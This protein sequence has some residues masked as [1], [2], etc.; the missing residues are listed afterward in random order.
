MEG[1]FKM[2]EKRKKISL[3]IL[4]VVLEVVIFMRDYG[5]YVN[6]YNSSIIALSYESGFVSRGLS[7]TLF[8]VFNM[9]MP[10]DIFNYNGVLLYT[11]IITIC[12]LLLILLFCFYLINKADEKN[13]QHVQI[14]T[15]LLVVFGVSFFSNSFN[16]GRVDIFLLI[17]SIICVFLLLIRKME[18]MVIPLSC[19]AVMF[20]QAY[21]FML[22]NVTLVILIYR[23]LEE[24]KKNKTKYAILFILSFVS[25][26]ILF[27]YLNFFAH[28]S[29]MEVYNKV[30]DAATLISKDTEG[31]HKA[32]L[33]HEILGIDPTV[34]ERE[35]HFK[36][37]V[38]FPFYALI[39]MPYI[40]L[41]VK[42]F[43][44]VIRR[45]YKVQKY[46]YIVLSIGVLTIVPNLILKVDYG[47]W[48]FSVLMYYILIFAYLVAKKDEVFLEVLDEE[49]GELKTKPYVFI[50]YVIPILMTPMWDV[51]IC[52]VSA[53][54]SG[55]LNNNFLHLWKD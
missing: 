28:T 13:Y 46:K 51:N 30:V 44:N 53:H 20:H 14:I 12:F 10:F 42:I 43:V 37:F 1:K 55:D 22:F 36:N 32:L 39:M 5:G 7:G 31:C 19:I 38:E 3:G 45:T 15:I 18:W 17:I 16:F 47:R 26:S 40:V 41:L 48:M 23:F 2:I 4:L 50:L 27:L 6:S 9:V 8:R 11:Q 52:R 29:D 34:S 49:V 35:H 54:I 33:Q 25:A 24:D 21:V